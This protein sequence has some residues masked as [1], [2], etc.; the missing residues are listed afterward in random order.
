MLLL[1]PRA[2]RR[3]FV[4]QNGRGSQETRMSISDPALISA[5]TALGGKPHSLESIPGG[6]IAS[7][8]KLRLSDGR[9]VFVK[10]G[11]PGPAHFA[12]EAAGLRALATCR[13]IR[14]PKVL[15]VGPDF[16]ALELIRRTGPARGTR[17]ASTTGAT[18]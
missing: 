12:A 8:W 13:A 6:S 17:A 10:T 1:L 14:V 3:F 9:D 2:C 4:C 18:C 7:A 16:L 5:A 11:Y 15:A